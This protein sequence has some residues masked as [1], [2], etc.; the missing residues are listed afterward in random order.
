MPVALL[1]RDLEAIEERI[2]EGQ[3]VEHIQKSFK[4]EFF[5]EL[6]DIAKARVRNEKTALKLIFNQ[7]DLRF[8]T[9][10]IVAQYRAKRLSCDV[11][12]ELCSGVGL[13]AIEFAKTCKKVIGIEIDP[14]KVEYARINAIL[15]KANNVEFICAD[16][17][18][19]KA[20]HI[21]KDAHPSVIF[22]DPQRSPSEEKRSIDTIVP[23]LKRLVEIYKNI[24]PEIVIE[25]PPQMDDS[26][27]TLQGEKEYLSVHGKLNRLNLYMGK[28]RKYPISVVSLPSEA[29]LPKGNTKAIL[30]ESAPLGYLHEVDTAII[31][32]NLLGEFLYELQKKDSQAALCFEE[33][34]RCIF[35][36]RKAISS[37]FFRNS[38]EILETVLHDKNMIAAT[39]KKMKVSEV[40]LRMHTDPKEYWQIRSFYEKQLPKQERKKVVHL[41]V[42]KETAYICS[43]VEKV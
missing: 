31:H 24:T 26:E 16:V 12:I 3:R 11:L 6:Y 9:P 43:K 39:L 27:I 35:T 32:A 40:I 10:Q 38:F 8:A 13:Q 37:P 25:L 18:G 30:Q 29:L 5:Q 19:E 42:N 22:C 21:V 34:E 23:S 15:A 1:L 41:F 28:L 33:H 20:V 36:S 7:Q 4:N 14:R 17:L 2:R